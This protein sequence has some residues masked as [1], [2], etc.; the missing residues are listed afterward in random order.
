VVV[1]GS[2]SSTQAKKVAVSGAPSDQLSKRD[3]TYPSEWDHFVAT[4]SL[5]HHE[6]CS[7]YANERANF[8]FDHTRITVRRGGELLAGAQ[9]LWQSTPLGGFGQLRRGPLA[10]RDD[11]ALLSEVVS[12]IDRRA[13]DQHLMSVRVDTL[14]E[15]AAARQALCSHGYTPSHTWGRG[16]VSLV[17]PVQHSSGD[18]LSMMKPK[19]RYG[20]RRA[21]RERVNVRIGNDAA[22]R[23][24][25]YLHQKTASHQGFRVFPQRYFESLAR[26][27]ASDGHVQWFVAYQEERPLAAIVNW[28]IGNR[29]IYTWGGIDR[30]PS[31][32]KLMANYLLH[33]R[34]YE[35]AR[36]RGL[37]K[38]DLSG[39][40]PFK[41][42]FP[43][44]EE[45]WPVALRKCYGALSGWRRTMIEMCGR[46]LKLR[47]VSIRAQ[48]ALGITVKAELPW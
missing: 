9:L 27:F 3:T 15:Q 8:G 43:V 10:M 1:M 38:Y 41:R 16:K 6:Q 36:Q 5:G 2:K 18:L 39:D 22:L 45:V 31:V 28:I 14:P 12:Q 21:E 48:R 47:R 4:Q 11:P 20:V 23:D 29:M 24:F 30:E 44:E 25:Y 46:N 37:Q 33:I 40:S 7:Q 34:A 26:Q 32:A 35:W 19:D 13:A 42:K 17:I